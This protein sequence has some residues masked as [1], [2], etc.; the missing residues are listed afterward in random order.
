MWNPFKKNKN[1]L[2]IPPTTG[3][4]YDM[5]QTCWGRSINS[6]KIIDGVPDVGQYRSNGK[7]FNG[8]PNQ[9]RWAGWMSPRPSVGDEIVRLMESGKNGVYRFLKVELCSDP[10]DMFFGGAVL[11]RYL[12]ENEQPVVP[13]TH[14]SSTF[15]DM[16]REEWLKHKSGG[17]SDAQN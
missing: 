16:S 7:L 15:K 14:I 1:I 10:P 11:V 9:V 17:V 12:D 3:K 5:R 6:M 2:Q 8:T 13:G 4:L